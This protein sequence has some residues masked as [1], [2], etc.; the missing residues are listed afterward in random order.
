MTQPV[1][2]VTPDDIDRLVRRDFPGLDPVEV[3]SKLHNYRQ[4]FGSNERVLA[5]I[6]KLASGDASAVDRYVDAANADPRDVLAWA[7]YPRYLNEVS[8]STT[9]ASRDFAVRADWEQYR[10][11]FDRL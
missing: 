11:W 6:L 1:P 2:T 5:A 8:P 4:T 7:E 10:S 9:G 3:I